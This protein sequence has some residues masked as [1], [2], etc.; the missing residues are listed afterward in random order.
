MSRS[1]VTEEAILE[2]LRVVE[3]PEVRRSIVELEMVKRI[4]ID[5]SK[6][7]VEVLLTIRG[8]PLRTVIEDQVR[9]AILAV[10]GVTS[11]TVTIGTMTDEERDRFA[12]KLR[13]TPEQTAESPLLNPHSTTRFIA[14]ASGKGGVGKSTVTANLAVAFARLGYRVGVVDADIYGFSLPSIFGI[15]DVKPVVVSNLILPVQTHDVK[16]VSMHF[17][18]PENRPV[19]WRGP[20]LGKML[21]NFFQEVHWGELDVM[22]LDLPPGTGDVA[23]DVH[24]MLPKSKELI[25]TTPHPNAADVAVRAGLMAQQVHHDII[26]VIENMA[27]YQCDQCGEKAYL[28]GR[29]GGDQVAETLGTQLLAQIPIGATGKA[30]GIF[31]ADSLQGEAFYEL[32]IGLASTLEMT[33]TKRKE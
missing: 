22:L 26:G 18:V 14:V 15:A 28:F 30:T 16:V 17:F 6:V 10:P 3:D 23:L 1:K 4:E 12:A 2:A 32:A 7:D 20:M 29:G 13:G 21:R 25:V 27:Y 9:E 31:T 8:C 11:A 33:P 24:N 5:G 19:I